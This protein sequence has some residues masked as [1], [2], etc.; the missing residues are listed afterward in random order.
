MQ[1]P[2][3]G[4][5]LG[6]FK[7]QKEPGWPKRGEWWQRTNGCIREFREPEAQNLADQARSLASV[8]VPMDA[9][10][11]SDGLAGPDSRLRKLVPALLWPGCGWG[12][13]TLLPSLIFLTG[14]DVRA[15]DFQ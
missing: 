4:N 2:W 11:V 6:L 14:W 7:G 8:M 1:R 12:F 5:E 13:R 15:G 9:T 3:G 10:A